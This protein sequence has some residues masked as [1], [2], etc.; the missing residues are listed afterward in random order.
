MTWWALWPAAIAERVPGL[1]V[2]SGVSGTEIR[3]M[4]VLLT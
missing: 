2:V 4:K 1:E 3:G